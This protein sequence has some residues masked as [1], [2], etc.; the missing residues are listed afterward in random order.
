MKKDFRSSQQHTCQRKTFII[1]QDIGYE[2]VSRVLESWDS[3]R[4]ESKDFEQLFGKMLVDKFVEFQPRTKNF[5]Q[6]DAMM[7]KHANGIV[8]LLDSILQNARPRHEVYSGN[9]P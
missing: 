1:M 2:T 6:G 4:Q 3:A 8:N 7:K 9:A 5:Y